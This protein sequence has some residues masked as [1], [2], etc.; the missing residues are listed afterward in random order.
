VKE[1]IKVKNLKKYYQVHRKEPGLVGSL[2]SL[3]SRKYYDVTG[4][5]A[6]WTLHA[7]GPR[8]ALKMAMEFVS[9]RFFPLNILPTVLFKIVNFLPFSFL[10]FFP[11]NLYLG[12]LSTSEIYRGFLTQIIWIAVFAVLLKLLWSRGLRRYEAVGG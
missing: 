1:S 5:T 8:F 6:F 11:L 3:I 10:V 12:R 4:L 2:K 9:G 7:Y